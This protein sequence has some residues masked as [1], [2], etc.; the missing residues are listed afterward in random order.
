MVDL[1]TTQSHGY[2]T[3]RAHRAFD[4]LLNRLLSRHGLSSGYWYIL[5]ALW[6]QDRQSQKA[7]A[8]LTNTAENTVATTVAGMARDGL[9]NRARSASD[10]RS[11][12][13]ALTPQGI[14]LR[15]ELMPYARLVNRVATKGLPADELE[16]CLRVLDRMAANLEDAWR[17]DDL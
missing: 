14:A 5:R 7:I 17:A 13:V 9:V 15:E 16:V 1:P 11:W 12:T 8:A 6:A 2:A 3:R 4:R 10:G